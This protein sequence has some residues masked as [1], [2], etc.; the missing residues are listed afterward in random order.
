MYLLLRHMDGRHFG[1]EVGQQV[2][3]GSRDRVGVGGHGHDVMCRC[4]IVYKRTYMTR[5]EADSAA[6]ALNKENPKD[7]CFSLEVEEPK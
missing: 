1:A 3:H 4:L 2:Y 5:E 7:Y 6:E